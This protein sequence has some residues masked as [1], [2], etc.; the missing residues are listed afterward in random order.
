MPPF[1]GYSISIG[2]TGTTLDST[3][4][5]AATAND[6]VLVG[7]MARDGPCDGEVAG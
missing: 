3:P 4:G 2:A 6:G 1:Y 7:R 5:A